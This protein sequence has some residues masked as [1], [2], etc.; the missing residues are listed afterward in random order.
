MFLKHLT[1]QEYES[2]VH[3]GHGLLVIL[4]V[5]TA[6]DSFQYVVLVRSFIDEPASPIIQVAAI[7]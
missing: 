3:I 1:Q 2:D 7:F 4:P 6:E 5:I